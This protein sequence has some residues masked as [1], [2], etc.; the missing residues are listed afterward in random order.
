[1]APFEHGFIPMNADAIFADLECGDIDVAIER[2]RSTLQSL[3]G[4]SI[5]LT[6]GSG[7]FGRWLLALLCRANSTLALDLN[8]TVL[9]RSCA[10]F[11]QT[12]PSLAGAPCVNLI[13]GDVR[14]FEY[15]KG[16][17]SYVIHGASDTS[18]EAA[19]RPLELADTIVGGTR[20]VLEFALQHETARVL[21]ISSGAVYG[22]QPSEVTHITEDFIG[23]GPTTEMSSV[24][25]Q[26]K[27]FA[28]QLATI[29]LARNG[30]ESVIARPF[31]FVGPGLPLDAHFAIGNFI[32]DA[33]A[34]KPILVTG[35]GEQTR[36]FLYAG[37][38]ASWLIRLVVDGQP[39][40]AYNVGSDQ[41][42][43]IRDLAAVVAK[44]IPTAGGVRVSGRLSSDDPRPRYVPSIARA[45]DELGLDVWTPLEEAIRRTARW[46]IRN[47][48]TRQET[49]VRLAPTAARPLT[50]IFDIDGVVASLTA[51]NDY[52]L[53][54]PRAAMIANINRLYAAGH[55]IVLFT[56]RGSQTAI[57]WQETTRMQLERWGLRFH[58]L[59]FGKPAGDYYI[60]DRGLTP[61][62]LAHLVEL[63]APS[64][65]T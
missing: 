37:D 6:G 61:S 1:M 43:S 5:F 9:T 42:I 52:A 34:G 16:R 20:R 38:L 19:S 46:A 50:F 27:R 60:D 41:S 56:A 35:G 14:F 49:P 17:F 63:V 15:P 33:I 62:E 7:F 59:R 22:R 31:A 48:G 32:R 58:E 18:V 36:A 24:Y 53:A 21:I 3:R 51:G 4:A 65:T 11:H 8:L 28:E 40:R 64:T 39:G 45:R 25:G 2:D 23:A 10:R 55:R 29:Y 30:L 47:L 44:A 57:D 54:E 12:H 26:A 13:E